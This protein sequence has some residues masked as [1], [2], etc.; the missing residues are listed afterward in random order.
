[1]DRYG[2][3]GEKLGYSLSPRIHARILDALGKEGQYDLYEVPPGSV[4][5]WIQGE[6][7]G[8]RGF[9]VTI[10]YKE[11]VIPYMN[12]LSDRARAVGAVNTVHVRDGQLSG[13][14]TDVY[15]FGEMLCTEG[16]EAK[17]AR[18]LIMGTGG[19]AK[20]VS[21]HFREAGA[22]EVT[23]A[24][25]DVEADTA[26]FP[27][28]RIVSYDEIASLGNMDILVNCTPV[29]TH[30]NVDDCLMEPEALDRYDTVVDLIYNPWQT[31]LLRYAVQ[32]GK[33]AVNGLYMLVAQAVRAQSVWQG[34]DIPGQ[35]T[36]DIYNTLKIQMLGDRL[37]LFLIG[38]MGSGKST[39]GCRAAKQL[40]H[41]FIDMDTGIEERHGPIPAI[42]ER[43][44]DVFRDIESQ[45]ARDISLL[46]GNVVACGGG[47]ILRPENM[48]ALR[49]KGIV[50]F[51]DRPIPHILEDI[52]TGHRPLLADGK[53]RLHAIFRERGPLYR[54]YADYVIENTGTEEDAIARIIAIA[55]G[56]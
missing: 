51:I 7:R 37:N 24:S 45:A 8:L 6:A 54:R 11:T 18:V 40:G 25:V 47:I 49:R 9:N 35:V 26:R 50:L 48:D 33:K 44:E 4:G 31:R 55:K 28:H 19:A 39:L 36:R 42:F 14:N 52:D 56:E 27:W 41:P 13:H 22:G 34:V 20:A 17:G 10:P 2:L 5:D 23:L 46:E 43:G 3:L 38:M 15:G 53:E 21:A 16:I 29:G 1:M 30:P 32:A 12:D